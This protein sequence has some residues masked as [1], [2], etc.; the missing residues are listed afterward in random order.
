[1]R[2]ALGVSA[3]RQ[4]ADPRARPRRLRSAIVRGPW[5]RAV[6]LT[7]AGAATGA[8]IVLALLVTA[9]ATAGVFNTGP[10]TWSARIAPF[11]RW[12][13][14]AASVNV[15]AVAR[16]ATSPLGARV[17]DGRTVDTR[18]G[19]LHFRRRGRTLIVECAPCTVTDARVAAQPIQAA[20][21][22][23]LTPRIGAAIP[24]ARYARVAGTVAGE[25][26]LQLPSQ[27]GRASLALAGLAVDGLGTEALA[28]GLF[29]Q[30]CAAR[31]GSP[32]RVLNG[33]GSRFWTPLD[34]L[35][36][37][38]PDAVLAAA[39]PGFLAHAGY[40]AQRIA[41]AALP[42]GTL[43]QR[44]A[45]TL[46]TGAEGGAAGELRALLYAVEMERTLGKRRILELYLNSADWGP[47]IC[48]AR[49]AAR[50]YFGKT[51]AQLTPLQAAWLA[52]GLR[53]PRAAYEREF[54]RGAPDRAA[55]LR[56]LAQMRE[57]TLDERAR[58]RREALTF[59]PAPSAAR[60]APAPLA[61]IR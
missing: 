44:L 60:G 58:A 47:G 59:A 21:D 22:V 50:A 7:A 45:R 4:A 23:R 48:G 1:L 42:A 11:S 5:V 39:D 46:F 54:L 15:P 27:V 49:A 20:L 6:A 35:G 17:L 28:S 26:T 12:P 24:E 56:V 32:R 16:L 19:R 9:A 61:A 13:G 55:A 40:D 29:E 30:P 33:E 51:P 8:L 38:L 43:T 57:L 31:D 53:Q 10:G 3:A 52:A 36:A 18:G 14:L 41:G 25:G 34:S 37:R 2:G